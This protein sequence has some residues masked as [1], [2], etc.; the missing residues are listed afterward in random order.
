M[1]TEETYHHKKAFEILIEF[2]QQY[3][4]KRNYVWLHE[5]QTRL[6]SKIGD[7]DPMF[8]D[9]LWLQDRTINQITAKSYY[10]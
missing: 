10:L 5:Y 8:S 9:P 4:W 3:E 7:D 1:D 6:T 2:L